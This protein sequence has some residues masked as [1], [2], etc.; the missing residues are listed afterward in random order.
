MSN[1]KYLNEHRV[2]PRQDPTFGTPASAGFNGLFCIMVNGLRVKCIASDGLGWKHV[3]VSVEGKVAAPPSWSVMCQVKDLFWEPGD[4]VVQFHP[5][6]SDYV[7]FHPGVLH[8]WQPLNAEL[9]K[10]D[11][12]MV[13]PRNEAD[14]EALEKDPRST[15]LQRLM[16]RVAFEAK[17]LKDLA[18]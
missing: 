6:A 5:G 8:L 15:P 7:N 10:P 3:S 4:W 2:S 11:S 13:G 14:L 17:K 16:T 9:P 12:M 18:R 1:W